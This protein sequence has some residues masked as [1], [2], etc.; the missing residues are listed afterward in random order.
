MSLPARATIE[1]LVGAMARVMTPDSVDGDIARI[2]G[3]N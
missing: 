1:G 2:K 3:S